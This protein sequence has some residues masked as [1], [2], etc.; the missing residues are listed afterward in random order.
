MTSRSA[1]GASL[2][3]TRDND[4]LLREIYPAEG[5]KGCARE[6]PHVKLA[7]IRIRVNTLGLRRLF[8]IQPAEETD[9]IA[10]AVDSAPHSSIVEA[11]R[12]QILS[13][14]E[15]KKRIDCELGSLYREYALLLTAT[16][17]DINHQRKV[18]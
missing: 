15:D 8:V 4:K 11:K 5:L 14:E 7:D 1:K 18:S 12:R 3:W 16:R 9:G 6:F 2:Q 10:V 13:K 17:R